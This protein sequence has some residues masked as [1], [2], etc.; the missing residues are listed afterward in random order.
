MIRLAWSKPIGLPQKHRARPSPYIVRK[1]RPSLHIWAKGL[2]SGSGPG[3]FGLFFLRTSI[4]R[5]KLIFERN[6]YFDYYK[7]RRI[8]NYMKHIKEF[9]WVYDFKTICEEKKL[10]NVGKIFIKNNSFYLRKSWMDKLH[11]SRRHPNYYILA[12]HQYYICTRRE[13]KI[14]D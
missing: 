12:F 14:Y 9:Y 3:Y 8:F 7:M 13:K 4:T 2:G 6:Y 5:N 1:S 10:N 11:T